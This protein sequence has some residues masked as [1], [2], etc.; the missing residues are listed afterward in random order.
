MYT[1]IMIAD[2]YWESI[3][4]WLM[5]PK[6]YRPRSVDVS[7]DANDSAFDTK[8]LSWSHASKNHIHYG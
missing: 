8:T 6:W 3:L 5:S 2:K 1:M 4:P 7:G